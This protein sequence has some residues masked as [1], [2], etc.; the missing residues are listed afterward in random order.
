L[1]AN[2]SGKDGDRRDRVKG[3]VDLVPHIG[4]LPRRRRLKPR[5]KAGCVPQC[6]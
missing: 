3:R 2:L 6:V 1:S 5:T 4:E